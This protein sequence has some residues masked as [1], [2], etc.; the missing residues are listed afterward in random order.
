MFRLGLLQ[1]SYLLW[2]AGSATIPETDPQTLSGGAGR[3]AADQTTFRHVDEEPVFEKHCFSSLIGV[4][5][6]YNYIIEILKDY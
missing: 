4:F 5:S 2:S 6:A 3:L 1:S